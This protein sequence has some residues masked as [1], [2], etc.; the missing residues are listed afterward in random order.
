MS[1]ADA[2]DR[3]HRACGIERNDLLA[4]K[5]RKLVGDQVSRMGGLDSYLIAVHP[6]SSVPTLPC[7]CDEM[8]P[9]ICGQPSRRSPVR[10]SLKTD[11]LS[12]ER[13]HSAGTGFGLPSSSSATMTKVAAVTFSC[14]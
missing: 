5:L 9:G 4:S 11:F 13:H 12:T 2:E 7:F 3:I 14:A 10:T 8:V 6:P 1:G